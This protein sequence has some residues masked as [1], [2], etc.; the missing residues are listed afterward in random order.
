MS[1]GYYIWVIDGENET[2]AGVW[3]AGLKDICREISAKYNRRRFNHGKE[4]TGIRYEKH[5]NILG[6]ACD[7]IIESGTL[8]GFD[9]R[10]TYLDRLK[11]LR[12][13]RV[14]R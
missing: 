7:T 11:T 5:S 4:I 2:P 1:E 10:A 9:L 14:A 8:T 3:S 12:P 6:S 13:I